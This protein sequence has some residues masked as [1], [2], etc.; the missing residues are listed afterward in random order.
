MTTFAYNAF[1]PRLTAVVGSIQF[2]VNWVVQQGSGCPSSKG[3]S[4]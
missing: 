1:D 2:Q 3:F 4:P